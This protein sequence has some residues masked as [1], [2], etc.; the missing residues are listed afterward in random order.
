MKSCR[1]GK[2]CC[3]RSVPAK[4]PTESFDASKPNTYVVIEYASRSRQNESI[5][6]SHFHGGPHAKE[7]W[8]WDNSTAP[9]S[10]RSIFVICDKTVP[11]ASTT[12]LRAHL[13]S[14]YS[15]LVLKKLRADETLEVGKIATLATT[16]I[17]WLQSLCE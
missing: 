17:K 1:D 2:D 16:E 11:M 7:K 6:L 15:D 8:L 12:N 10:K 5:I 13:Q 4:V 9:A 3:P 14:K